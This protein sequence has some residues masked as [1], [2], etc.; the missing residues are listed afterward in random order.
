ML[1]LASSPVARD[2]VLGDIWVNYSGKR[3]RRE[4]WEGEK[5]TIPARAGALRSFPS[6]P[7]RASR[8]HPALAYSWG[9]P[10]EEAVLILGRLFLSM[11]LL[12]CIPIFYPWF[13]PVTSFFFFLTKQ[14]TIPSLK[15]SVGLSSFSKCLDD[16]SRNSNIKNKQYHLNF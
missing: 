6:P 8:L 9:K 4:R 10:V 13:H 16:T 15:N 7:S 14:W 3:G 12:N 5:K 11:E 1:R 2:H